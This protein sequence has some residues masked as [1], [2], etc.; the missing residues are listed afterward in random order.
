MKP[1][2]HLWAI[3]YDDVARAAQLRDEI[4]RLGWGQGGAAKY[5]ILLDVAVVVRQPDGSFVIDHKSFPTVANVLGCS[6]VGFLAGLVLGA[7]IPG[8]VAGAVVGTMGSAASASALG[9]DNGFVRE[10]KQLM[11]PGTAAV[12]ALDYEGDMEII[13][14]SIRGLGGTVLKSN[15]DRERATLIQSALSGAA[16]D[17]ASGASR[18]GDAASATG[19]PTVGGGAEGH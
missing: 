12:F 10:V 17:A 5:L 19:A 8:A 9:I 14:H 11:K 2:A 18:R 7:P 1:D 6:A 16:A 13:L 15:V 3:G 4:V